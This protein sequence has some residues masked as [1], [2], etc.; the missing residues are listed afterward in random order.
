LLASVIVV[1]IAYLIGSASFAVIVS[2]MS[3]LPDPRSYGSGNPG[4][5]NVLRSGSK[6]AAAITLAGDVLKGVVAVWLAKLA[7]SHF[8]G[9]AAAVPLAGLAAFLGHLYPV[10]FHFQG[11][12][13]VATAGGILFA[14]SVPVGLTAMVTWAAVFA[15]TRISSL[16]ALSAAVAAALAAWHFLGSVLYTK[17][18]LVMVVL[19]VWRHRANIRKLLSGTEGKVV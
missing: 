7:T 5:T 6:A 3:G 1:V 12:K 10:F 14:F 8:G 16:G 19:L 4:A 9:E 17:V 13:G 2:A 18:I 11:G 15:F